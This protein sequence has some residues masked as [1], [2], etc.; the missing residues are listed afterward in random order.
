MHI[1]LKN[2][3]G[4]FSCIAACALIYNLGIVPNRYEKIYKNC[5]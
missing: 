4:G 5:A 2:V 1:K 3:S